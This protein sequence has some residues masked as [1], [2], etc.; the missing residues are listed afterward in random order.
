MFNLTPIFGILIVA[1]MSPE[2]SSDWYAVSV[3]Y[4][5][6]L[7]SVN[8]SD[9]CPTASC[10]VLRIALSHRA[11]ASNCAVSSPEETVVM[12]AGG[13]EAS[14][15]ISG[16]VRHKAPSTVNTTPSTV[17]RPARRA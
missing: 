7:E 6:W 12:A 2:P 9:A 11:A 15:A 1:I 17:I 5:G 4:A 13:R 16:E 10:G 3:I 8:G 14:R